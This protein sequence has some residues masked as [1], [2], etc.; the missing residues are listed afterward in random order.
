[1]SAVHYHA[2]I[3]NVAPG[4]VRLDL[5]WRLSRD[6]P[7]FERWQNS[8]DSIRL[9]DDINVSETD[10][11]TEWQY[12]QRAIEAYRVFI[13]QQ[14]ENA[15]RQGSGIRVRP[16]MDS[17]Y[18]GNAQGLS[19]L[20]DVQRYSVAVHWIGA[21]A[22]LITGSDLTTLDGLGKE[23]LFNDEALDVAAFT[24]QWP[25]QPRG[26]AAAQ[27]QTWVAG[28][29]DAGTAVVVLA[30]YGPDEGEGGFGTS[31]DGVQLVSST[32]D[33]LG[34]G[35]SSWSVRRVWGGGGSGGGDHQDLGVV[36][37]ELAS[38]LG[39]NESVLYKLQRQ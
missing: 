32:L 12:V 19:G 34:L 8:A 26:P 10:H 5:S 21:G 23:L 31:I 16:D 30:N 28:P 13:N 35:E 17:L 15:T 2:A 27:L 14:T 4:K 9:D 7:Y 3:Q 11:L 25:M 37:D 29:N 6:A 36:S 33:N 20:S 39:P 18:V 22:N 38:N 24:A 1:M